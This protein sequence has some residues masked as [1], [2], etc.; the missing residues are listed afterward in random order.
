MRLALCVVALICLSAAPPPQTS[1]P[2]VPVGVWY[3]GGTVRAPMVV[4]DP[5]PE[6]DGVAPRPGRDQVAGIQQRQDLGGLGERRARARPVPVRRARS[7]AVARRGRRPQ[8]HRPDLHGCRPRVAGEALSGFELRQRP[9]RAHRLPGVAG[10][11]PRSRRRARR[12]GGVHRGGVGGRRQAPG[13]LRDRRLERA[14]PGQLG[15]VQHARRVLL[16]PAHAGALPR[17]AQG[18][19][20]DARG[21]Q[22]RVVSNVQLVGRAGGAALRHHPLV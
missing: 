7:A 20:P 18:A 13:L 16:L 9:R 10:L 21:A 22:P 11:L 3:G 17:V 5:A 12:H 14:A 15:V 4:R 2:F 8:G 6:R 19:I 1:E